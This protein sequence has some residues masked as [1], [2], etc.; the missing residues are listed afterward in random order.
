[1]LLDGHQWSS[2]ADTRFSEYVAVAR[3]HLKKLVAEH[4][5]PRDHEYHF[6][7][8]FYADDTVMFRIKSVAS[9]SEFMLDPYAWIMDG[10]RD[11]AGADHWY[12]FEKDWD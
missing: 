6:G 2:K 1:M 7:S 8:R 5:A 11:C 10:L 12:A 4:M 9:E 3:K